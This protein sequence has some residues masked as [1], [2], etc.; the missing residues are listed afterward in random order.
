MAANRTAAK[1]K[2]AAGPASEIRIWLR[3]E[4]RNPWTAAEAALHEGVA[5]LMGQDRHK[6]DGHR[7]ERRHRIGFLAA[8][9][10]PHE[11]DDPKPG[12]DA[13]RDIEQPKVQIGLRRWWFGEDHGEVKSGESRARIDTTVERCN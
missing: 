8:A 3:G 13:H 6:H 10:S 2:P 9:D 5:E 7:D 12:M 11:R 1:A 4:E